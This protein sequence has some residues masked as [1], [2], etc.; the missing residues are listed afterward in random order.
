MSN[1]IPCIVSGR[2]GL[3]EEVENSGIIVHDIFNISE[4]VNAIKKFDDKT[5]Y[6]EISKKAKKKALEFEDKVQF[7][8][9]DQLLKNLK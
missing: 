4:W 8:K 9:F 6:N 2:G 5:F 7:K 1:G 3:I